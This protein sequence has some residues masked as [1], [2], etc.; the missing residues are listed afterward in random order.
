MLKKN[1]GAAQAEEGARP[2]H[3]AWKISAKEIA[4]NYYDLDRKNPHEVAVEHG[5]PEELMSEY[6]RILDELHKA[7]MAL[8]TELIAALTSTAVRR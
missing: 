2:L 6:Q 7:Q 8:K 5:E 3:N 1:G 4:E